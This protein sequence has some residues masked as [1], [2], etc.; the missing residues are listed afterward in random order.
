LGNVGDVFRTLQT[1]N[2]KE[3][4]VLNDF[5]LLTRSAQRIL[6]RNLQYILEQTPTKLIIVGNWTN[7]AYLTDLSEILPNFICEVPVRPWSNE[8]S[9]MF[10]SQVEKQ[11]NISF[12]GQ[13]R[14]YLIQTSAGSVRDLNELCRT[15]LQ[16]AGVGS[17]RQA[18]ELISTSQDLQSVLQRRTSRLANRYRETLS[19][20]LTIELYSLEG[21]DLA[22]LFFRRLRNSVFSYSFDELQQALR[23]AIDEKNVPRQFKR[24]RRIRLVELLS[25][26]AARD[27]SDVSV[28]FD[29]FLAATPA[30][31]PPVDRIQ[32]KGLSE[33]LLK[34]QFGL[35]PRPMLYDP[36]AVSLVAV[37]PAFRSFL[38]TING[39][40]SDIERINYT[41]ID[42]KRYWGWDSKWEKRIKR[43]AKLNRWRS[44]GPLETRTS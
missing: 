6:V 31:E 1:Q 22:Q 11:L 17:R 23:E 8:D 12:D 14:T 13:V 19:E 5:H 21:V 18:V 44:S 30:G 40:V 27:S 29:E 7:P 4:I 15:L 42:D 24:H 10:L 43:Q 2:A 39:D 32:F 36:R 37:E 35:H 16:E 25:Q 34:A 33:A 26:A 20:Y 38:A 3:F 41:L 9:S 28:S